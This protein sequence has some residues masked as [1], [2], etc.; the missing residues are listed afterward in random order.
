MSEKAL[1]LKGGTR[2]SC[3]TRSTLFPTRAD[4]LVSRK[5]GTKKPVTKIR[6]R[7]IF[8]K[9]EKPCMP[10]HSP[11]VWAIVLDLDQTLIYTY[12]SEPESIPE[13]LKKYSVGD[14]VGVIR[15]HALEFLDYLKKH[16]KHVIVW[17]AGTEAYANEISRILFGDNHEIPVFHRDYCTM[18]PDSNLY[19]KPLTTISES[20]Q[21][22]IRHLLLID[23]REENAY[24]E[25]AN[26][27]VIK[28]YQGEEHD[29][30]LL[31]VAKKLSNKKV[32]RSDSV[33]H[34]CYDLNYE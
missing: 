24:H 31:S 15:P 14:T 1:K 27:L 26:C 4:V 21:I 20:L 33:R 12:D 18:I 2:S 10:T 5:R 17:T 11:S 6:Q 3:E 28:A 32:N 7:P 22:P 16:F 25:P 8:R 29:N 30:E 13:S 9:K 34:V 19:T 23:D